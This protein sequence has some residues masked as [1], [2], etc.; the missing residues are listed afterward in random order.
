[1]RDKKLQDGAKKEKVSQNDGDNE[2]EEPRGEINP[3]MAFGR[4]ERAVI[5][6]LKTKKALGKMI[7]L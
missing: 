2:K 3:R 5:L 6:F 1:M 4:K 7:S